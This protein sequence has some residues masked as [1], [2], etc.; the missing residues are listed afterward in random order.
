MR[1]LT[2]VLSPSDEPLALPQR[3]SADLAVALQK[4]LIDMVTWYVAD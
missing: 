1:G 4:K 2:G 3:Q